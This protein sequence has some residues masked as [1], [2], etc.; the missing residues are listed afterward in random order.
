MSRKARL[1]AEAEAAKAKQ[2]DQQRRAIYALGVVLVVLGFAYMGLIWILNKRDIVPIPSEG[3]S[4][5]L[6]LFILGVPALS[7]F[8][9]GQTLRR[10]GHDDWRQRRSATPSYS[11]P[12]PTYFCSR[13]N[14]DRWV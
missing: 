11:G 7:F 10:H 4:K 3:M 2:A 14:I 6:T 5:W 8:Y 13:G 12:R 1:E 9:T